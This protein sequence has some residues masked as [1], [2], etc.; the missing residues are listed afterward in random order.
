M[1]LRRDFANRD[2]LR[3]YLHAEFSS[4]FK[5]ESQTDFV[6]GQTAARERLAAIDP[7]AYRATRNQ[8]AGAVT[9]LAPYIR[10]GVLTLADL[11]AEVSRRGIKLN[12]VSKF[13]QELT[14]REYYQRVW[15]EIGDGIWHDREPYKTGFAATDYARALPDDIRDGT[16]GMHCIDAFSSDLRETGY[17]HNHVRMWLAAYVVHARR[18]RWQAGAKWFLQH[19][20]DGDPASNNLSW[21]W[22][23]STCSHKPYIFNRE[24]LQRLTGN[25]YCS[26]CPLFG[27]CTFEGTYSDVSSRWF[28]NLATSDE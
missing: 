12:S 5:T 13:M 22:I 7:A 19:L 28:P 10:H 16:T 18:L 21:Q 24:N 8:L 3:E 1:E 6:G 23:A 14:W 11:K 20:L 4:A 2:E 27:S 25:T 9:R 26:D 15:A 17:L